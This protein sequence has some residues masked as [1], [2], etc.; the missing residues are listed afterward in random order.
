MI[1]GW[2]KSINYSPQYYVTT[3]NCRMEH[4][5]FKRNM[6]AK[7]FLIFFSLL[8]SFILCPTKTKGSTLIPLRWFHLSQFVIS[9]LMLKERVLYHQWWFPP[10][11][12][13]KL[14]PSDHFSPI[15]RALLP[16][17]RY[18]PFPQ[19]L[20]RN[21]KKWKEYLFIQ[22]IKFCINKGSI[23]ECWI[24]CCTL[25]LFFS[26]KEINSFLLFG[27]IWLHIDFIQQKR[28]QIPPLS[29]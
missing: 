5:L 10:T 7:T 13:F 27:Y 9:I 24:G 22:C 8:I 18:L 21:P 17:S 29:R 19:A 4:F 6:K 11:L 28:E 16:A 26:S 1:I 15:F 23:C 20:N 12:L 2:N 3:L 14:S 25:P